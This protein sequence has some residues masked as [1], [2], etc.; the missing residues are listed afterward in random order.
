[1][2]SALT[3]IWNAV[4]FVVGAA[5]IYAAMVIIMCL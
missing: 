2:K 1:M 4:L 3:M 5:A